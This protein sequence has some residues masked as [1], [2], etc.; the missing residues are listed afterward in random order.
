VRRPLRVLTLTDILSS[1]GGAE[2]LATLIAE[3]LDPVRFERWICATRPIA[4][5][6]VVGELRAAGVRIVTL[7]RRGKLDL[8][9]WWPLVSLLRRERIDVVHAHK[10]GSNVWAASLGRLAGVPVVVSH[11]HTWSYV[12]QPVRRFLDR[13]LVARFSDAF[14]AVSPEDRRRMIEVER[15]PPER[16]RLILNAV[17]DHAPRGGDLRAELGLPAGA[18]LIGSVGRIRPQKAHDFLVEV[19]GELPGV[20]AVVAGD[21]EPA[22]VEELRSRIAAA[23][24]EG[25]VHLLGRRDDVADVLEAVDVAVLTSDFE[26][27]P[28]SVMEYMAAGK[29]IVSTAVGGVP[30]LIEDGVHGLLVPARDRVAM[31][32]AIDALLR[33][34]ERAQELGRRAAERRRAEFDAA[35]MLRRFEAL[36]EELFART[37]RAGREGWSPPA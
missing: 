32:T 6:H 13:E 27:A 34:P 25:R 10:F 31:A 17:P 1:D 29:P 4:Q 7:R 15:I 24:L 35:A 8:A 23:G 36:Y 26:G 3:S 14:V 30:A 20:H 12:G 37:R 11:E 9:A 18:P 21:G 22:L 16:I 33:D 28:L 19:V 2:R 5:E